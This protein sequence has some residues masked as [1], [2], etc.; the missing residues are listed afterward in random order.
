MKN[1]AL[2]KTIVIFFAVLL[3]GVIS[4]AAEMQVMEIHSTPF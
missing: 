3:F 2:K 4:S 1:V